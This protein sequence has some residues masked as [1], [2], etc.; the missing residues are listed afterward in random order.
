MTRCVRAIGCSN[1]TSWG[2]MKNL[3]EAEKHKLQRFDTAEQLPFAHQ[4]PL[5]KRLRRCAGKKA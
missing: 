4:P 1:E 3:W 5:R 2:L